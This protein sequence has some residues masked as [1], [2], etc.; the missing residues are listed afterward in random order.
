[1][2]SKTFDV[3]TKCET[4]F[5]TTDVLNYTKEFFQ[6]EF[7]I[8]TDNIHASQHVSCIPLDVTDAITNIKQ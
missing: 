4:D 1:M 7:N 5:N 6:K 2:A 8:H 3:S